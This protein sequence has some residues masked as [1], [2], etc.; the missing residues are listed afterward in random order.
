M[1]RAKGT[2]R[3]SQ[4]SADPSRLRLAEQKLS[5]VILALRGNATRESKVR[6]LLLRSEARRL[7]GENDRADDDISVAR[8][9]VPNEPTV[10]C[11]HARILLNNDDRQRAISELREAVTISDRRHDMII[12]LAEALAAG[13]D[14]GER[15]EAVRL[16]A[17]LA[18]HPGPLPNGLREHAGWFA[19]QVI[20]ELNTALPEGDFLSRIPKDSISLTVARAFRAKLF[21]VRQEKDE[22]TRFADEAIAS[23]VESTTTTDLR[24]LASLLSDLGRYNDALKLWQRISDPRRLNTDTYNLLDCAGRL[25][26][27]DVI[28]KICD[29]LRIAGVDDADL[30]SREAAIRLV[31]EP[32]KAIEILQQ[33]LVR[34]N[35]ARAIRLQLSSYAIQL[36]KEELIQADR[37]SLPEPEEISASYW[38]LVVQV[39]IAGGNPQGALQYAYE[40]LRQHFSETEA[41]R[42]YIA[43]LLPIETHARPDIRI[44]NQVEPGAAVC[45]VETG[46]TQEQ[47]RII[48]E[49]YVTNGQLSE[50]PPEHFLATQLLGKKVGDTF[51]LSPPGIAQRTGEIRRIESKYVYRYQDCLESFQVRFPTDADFEMVRVARQDGL[52]VSQSMDFSAVFAAVDKRQEQLKHVLKIYASMLLP[53]N[54][55]ANALGQS[56]FGTMLSLANKPDVTVK[57]CLGGAIER[58]EAVDGLLTASAIVVDLTAIATI[59]T[60]GLLDYLAKYLKPFIISRGTLMELQELESEERRAAARVG[61]IVKDE[62]RYVLTEDTDQAKAARIKQLVDLID[63][64]TK[65]CR[66][67]NCRELAAVEPE[68]RTSLLR[69]FGRHGAES[70]VLASQ[71][72]RVLWTDDFAVA[73][74]A[75]RE[76]GVRRVWTQLL[77]QALTESG[78]IDSALFSDASA[79]LVGYGYYFTSL[80]QS[81]LVAAVRISNGDPNAWPLT[82]ALASFSDEAVPAQDVLKLAI[83][84]LVEIFK[85]DILTTQ[86]AILIRTLECI[87]ARKNGIYLI[88]TLQKALPLAMGLNVRR[89]E[90]V[91]NI[92]RS[93]LSSYR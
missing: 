36:G 37:A 42:A 28:L 83:Q 39:M 62:G 53:L 17:E 60:L 92:I 50:V 71:P 63:S 31:Y 59:T 30:V 48:E 41:H 19:L 87:A 11:E 5:E 73:E 90:A 33:Y 52:G 6:A 25:G 80:N 89:A 29:Q 13:S 10:L 27:H 14:Q 49:H 46:T 7:L 93:W 4:H 69:A 88:D 43:A 26:K 81:V 74:L 76:F 9:I 56:T 35:D 55:V 2:N 34:H 85:E 77:L 21:F 78:S 1:I 23:V 15:Q 75:K 91:E 65:L 79:R 24:I 32:D 44:F 70:I 47:W 51:L 86:N 57:C 38:P 8:E 58:S 3:E 54:S 84:L 20:E 66:V 22:A 18:T 40:L 68:R 61:G 45:F 12:C 64:V 72:G 67:S 16:F 82:Q